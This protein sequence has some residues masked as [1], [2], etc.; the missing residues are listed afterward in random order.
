[1]YVV[2]FRARVKQLDAAYAETAERMQKLAFAEFGCVG[3]HS[4]EQDGE[5]LTL[6][7]WPDLASIAAWKAHPEHQ[8]AQELGR[9]RWYDYY[10]VEVAEVGRRYT[11]G[12]EG[13][14]TE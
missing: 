9:E 12:T 8:R 13:Q 2:I 7:Y 4:L 11:F 3:F 14:R 10:S 5:E 6:S 1:M